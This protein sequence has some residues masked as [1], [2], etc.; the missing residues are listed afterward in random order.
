MRPKV[1]WMNWSVKPFFCQKFCFHFFGQK[2]LKNL[3]ESM[4]TV[5]LEKFIFYFAML[6]IASSLCWWKTISLKLFFLFFIFIYGFEF[7]DIVPRISSLSFGTVNDIQAYIPT[8]QSIYRKVAPGKLFTFKFLLFS[9]DIKN[10]NPSQWHHS[11]YCVVH[12]MM[13]FF[14]SPRWRHCIF[15]LIFST[16]WKFESDITHG[17]TFL[18]IYTL[19]TISS[20]SHH[21]DMDNCSP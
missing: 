9:I 5:K 1:V 21:L 2:N 6:N 11:R 19:P 7:C 16:F 12:P 8:I 17:S 20:L 4:L 14:S 15:Q 18:C 3:Y 10:C 13:S